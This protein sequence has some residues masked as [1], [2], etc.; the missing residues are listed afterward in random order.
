MAKSKD[1]FSFCPCCGQKIVRYKHGLNRTLVSGLWHLHNA[2][3]RARIDKLGMTLSES[4]NFQKLR[5]F[6]LAKPAGAE[7]NNEW[8]L[9]RAGLEFLQG[10]LKVSRFVFTKLGNPVAESIERIFIHEVEDLI[11]FKVEWQ[12]QA[13]QP[14]LFDYKESEQ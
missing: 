11:S 2:G 10:R 9:T 14:N 5:Y 3:G 1:D 4:T 6:K 8:I 12:A 7:S 13:A